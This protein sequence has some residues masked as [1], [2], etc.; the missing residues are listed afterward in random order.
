MKVFNTDF[1]GD[2][3]DNYELFGAELPAW[4]FVL[5]GLAELAIA[6]LIIY[7]STRV[8][9]AAA[10]TTFMVGAVDRQPRV[11]EGRA[12]RR[13]ASL[14]VLGELSVYRSQ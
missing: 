11:G 14:P 6:A 5:V 7:P 12:R 13:C 1:R 3:A 10:L 8:I 9:G 2:M 4:F